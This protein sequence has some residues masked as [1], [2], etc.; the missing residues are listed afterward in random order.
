MGRKLLLSSMLLLVALVATTIYAAEDSGR[1]PGEQGLATAAD[2]VRAATTKAVSNLYDQLADLP[3]S[4]KYTVRQFLQDIKA[5]DEFMEEL[6]RA[7]QI[8]GPRWIDDNTCQ[9]RIEI[10]AARVAQSLQRIAGAH[11]R[12]TPLSAAVIDRN[13]R[14]W[15]QRVIAATGSSASTVTL[16]VIR[17]RPGNAWAS[18]GDRAREDALRAANADA[19]RQTMG[20]V[21]PV[22][23]SRTHTIGSAFG[24]AK[25]ERGVHQWLASRPVTSVDFRDDMYVEIVLAVDERDFYDE[26]RAALAADGAGIALPTTDEE[27][28][29]VRVNFTARFRPAVGRAAVNVSIGPRTRA[30]PVRIP[31]RAPEWINQPLDV[32]GSAPISGSK[33]RSAVV[34]EGHARTNLQQRIEALTLDQNLTLGQAAAQDPRV[35]AAVARAVKQARIYKTDYRADGTVVIHLNADMR[36]LWDDL[37]R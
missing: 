9:V 28:D 12:T 10:T 35:G 29:Q 16:K 33:L 15:P 21:A 19:I 36:P 27:W 5:Q 30:V 18:V 31:A 6:Q 20:C 17:P 26:V 25:V 2:V 8:G 7:D 34:A 22:P 24:I 23:L 3:L 1:Q 4:S 11:A 14:A 13:V 32:Q 37:A